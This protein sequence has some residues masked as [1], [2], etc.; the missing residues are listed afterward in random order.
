MSPI[1][2]KDDC[3]RHCQTSDGMSMLNGFPCEI[4]LRETIVSWI[5]NQRRQEEIWAASNKTNKRERKRAS[6]KI[7]PVP[8][9]FSLV[10][11]EA[12]AECLEKNKELGKKREK[13]KKKIY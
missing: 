6:D 8:C 4:N 7:P 12:V 9:W 5:E 13:K 11:R 10:Q 2:R 3:R 1:L